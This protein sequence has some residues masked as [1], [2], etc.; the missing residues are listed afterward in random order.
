MTSVL[1]GYAG[2]QAPG[3]SCRSPHKLATY[4]EGMLALEPVRKALA[5][6]APAAE[7]MG[8]DRKFLS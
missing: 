8:L 2:A 3:F 4:A 1:L 6:E 5:G 7:R